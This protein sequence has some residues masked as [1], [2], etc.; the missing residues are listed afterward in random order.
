MIQHKDRFYKKEK[1]LLAYHRVFFLLLFLWW[2]G[3]FLFYNFHTPE[4]IAHLNGILLDIKCPVQTN[5]SLCSL[6]NS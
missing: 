5:F 6:H 1:R 2:W 4:E 3:V